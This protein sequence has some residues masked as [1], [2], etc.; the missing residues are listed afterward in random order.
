M[1]FCKTMIRDSEKGLGFLM[2]YEAPETKAQRI[3]EV[4]DR[5]KRMNRHSYRDIS[6]ADDPL[7]LDTP[8][9]T[10]TPTVAPQETPK[11]K[12]GKYYKNLIAQ[13]W[14]TRP[15]AKPME[16][17]DYV[18]T[19]NH[20]YSN[21]PEP[22][23]QRIIE[24]LTALRKWAQPEADNINKIKKMAWEESPTKSP[25][26][27]KITPQDVINVYKPKESN[28]RKKNENTNIIKQEGK[29]GQI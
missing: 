19:M 3:K 8:V 4:G 23:N 26:P 29:R 21:E 25:Q 24:Q 15:K 17:V 5:I 14:I 9:F 16:V 28:Q 22:T 18:N 1:A 2:A 7:N 20:L 27:K 12:P 6:A 10:S 13:K 11:K